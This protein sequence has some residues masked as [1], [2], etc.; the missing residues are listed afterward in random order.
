MDFFNKLGSNISKG[1]SVVANKTKDLAGTTKIN[2]Q[3]SQD[4]S[5]INGLFTEIGKIYFKKFGENPS[6]EF[7]ASFEEINTIQ[8]RIE[9][10]RIQ[11]QQIRGSKTCPA[12]GG[13]IPSNVA[14][15][16]T[17]GAKAPDAPVAVV[18]EAPTSIAC[19]ACGK[20]EDASTAFCSGCGCK[21][22]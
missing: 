4:E 11:L 9:A 1:A 15:C 6:E 17:C 2:L 21:L 19:P 8:A 10:A 13:E 14:F 16:A 3:I 7:S 18:V 12:C 20:I 22:K 5:K